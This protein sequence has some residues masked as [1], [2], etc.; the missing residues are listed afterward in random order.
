MKLQQRMERSHLITTIAT[1]LFYLLSLIILYAIF[2]YTDLSAQ[3]AGE[4]AAYVADDISYLVEGE[5]LIPPLANDLIYGLGIVPTYQRNPMFELDKDAMDWMVILD[6]DM[7]VLASNIPDT[8]PENSNFFVDFMQQPDGIRFQSASLPSIYIPNQRIH[9]MY[10]SYKGNYFG[11]S[12][13]RNEQDQIIGYVVLRYAYV[14]NPLTSNEIL[15]FLIGGILLTM[16]LSVAF[17]VLLSKRM[18]KTLSLRIN[19]ITKASRRLAEGQS[20]SPIEGTDTD[21]IDQLASSFN[22][23]AATI[24]HQMS[25]LQDQMELKQSIQAELEYLA[26]YDALTNLLNRRTFMNR[27]EI[28]FSRNVRYQHPVC[29]LMIDLDD[30]KEINDTYGHQTGDLVLCKMGETILKNVRSHD[31]CGR[32]GGEEFVILM[33]ESD[34]REAKI[35]ANRILEKV[36]DMH[37][38]AEDITFSVSCSIGIADTIGADNPNLMEIINRADACLYKA[39]RSGKNKVAYSN[40]K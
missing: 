20:F 28:E 3:W 12:E 17:A 36:N 37:L 15:Y 35:M 25:S 5:H 34:I 26:S 7:I 14:A 31:L 19:K 23:M 11:F 30:F 16:S 1:M 10:G 4:K 2:S 13:I 38:E 18:S 21:E 9:Y 39:K 40:C 27:A 32:Y 8:F 29:V 24:K 6:D 33:P 22:Q